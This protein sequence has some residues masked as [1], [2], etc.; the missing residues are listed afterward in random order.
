MNREHL[1]IIFFTL[2]FLTVCE[3]FPPWLYQNEEVLNYYSAGYRWRFD[4]PKPPTQEEADLM[5]GREPNFETHYI[6]GEG[7]KWQLPPVKM[8]VLQNKTRLRGQEILIIAA[9][10]GA[11]LFLFN[12][13]LFIAL[14]F[15]G[16]LETAVLFVM[17]FILYGLNME[18]MGTLAF[19]PLFI[20]TACASIFVLREAWFD[21][22]WKIY[23]FSIASALLPWLT[24]SVIGSTA[25]LDGTGGYFWLG[26]TYMSFL[27]VTAAIVAFPITLYLHKYLHESI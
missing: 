5:V 6:I 14:L 16:L 21:R 27:V 10:L 9:A 22:F 12:R 19:F 25:S 26:V 18:G 13:R 8:R 7:P 11:F 24:L 2:V 4:P 20:A 3:L 17:G 15:P 23:L 1:Y